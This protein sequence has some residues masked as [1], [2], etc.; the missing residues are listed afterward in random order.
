MRASCRKHAVKH[1]A[2]REFGVS[3]EVHP[4]A[5]FSSAI[6]GSFAIIEGERPSERH[7]NPPMPNRAFCEFMS[8]GDVCERNSFADLEARPTRFKGAVQIVRR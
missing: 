3:Y 1:V 7:Y 6:D 8:A 2:E 4:V 5:I